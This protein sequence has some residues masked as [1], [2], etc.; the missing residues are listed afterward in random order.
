[1]PCRVVRLI[2]VV[3]WRDMSLTPPPSSYG[4]RVQPDAGVRADP[5]G[6]VVVVA[7]ELLGGG[8][9]HELV[10]LPLAR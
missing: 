3:P 5:V 6:S 10:A 2:T 1:M 9:Q 8:A 7:C 4:F